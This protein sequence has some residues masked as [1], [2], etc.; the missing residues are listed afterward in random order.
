M[1]IITIIFGTTSLLIGKIMIVFVTWYRTK[2][3]HIFLIY[4]VSLSMIIFNLIMSAVI[5]DL[6]LIEKPERIRQ[7]VGG[8][9]DLNAYKYETLL[10]IFKFSAILSFGSVW[11]TTVVLLRA[12][13]D[14]LVKVFQNWGILSIP[15]IYFLFSYFVEDIFTVLFFS[16]LQSDPINFSLILTSINILNKPIG[17]LIFGLVFWRISKLIRFEKTLREYMI[18]SGFGFL[19]LFGANQPTSLALG[20]FP[21]FG[22]ASITILIVSAYLIVI[23]IFVSSQFLSSNANLRR[24]LY[25]KANEIR[26]LQDI[27]TVEFEKKI[28]KTVNTVLKQEETSSSSENVNFEMDPKE[29]KDYIEEVLN[30]IKKKRLGN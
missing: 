12:S 29:L 20:P 11:L 14:P 4:S 10:L 28:E 7:F 13:K 6:L 9:I 16:F 21:P 15:I 22:I 23:G 24:T 5:L 26:L 1:I 27:G 2:R 18:L 19:L 25:K 3:N 17:G 8:S 30:E